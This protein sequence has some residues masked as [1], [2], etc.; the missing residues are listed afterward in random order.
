MAFR[1]AVANNIFGAV[2]ADWTGC[3]GGFSMN[4]KYR[5]FLG[6]AATFVIVTAP[7]HA[8]DEP[9]LGDLARQQRQQ[10]EQAKTTPGK[11]AKPSKVI[12]N[13]QLPAHSE[14]SSSATAAGGKG[15][16]HSLPAPSDESKQPG[17]YWKSQIL[18]Q[19]SQIDGLQKQMDEVNES[20]RFAPGN[21][22]GHCVEW[23]EHQKQKQEQV[24]RM[25]AQLEE[26]KKRLD[27]MQEA[28]RQQ[29]YGS[30]VYDP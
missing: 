1:L 10:K 11:D 8:Q 12:T 6:L 5:L 27:E 29:G 25:Q 2:Q 16:H 23:N 28:A 21:C 17:E 15:S 13:E 9:S 18:A 4:L 22:V 19:K 24:E 26:Q 7:A 30:S 3:S 14:P 20:I